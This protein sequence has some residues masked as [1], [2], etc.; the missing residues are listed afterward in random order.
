MDIV[1]KSKKY[2][3]HILMIDDEDYD[4]IKEHVWHIAFSKEKKTF[5]VL[6]NI[7]NGEK[8]TPKSIHRL[9]TNC[10]KGLVVD[11]KNHN[12]FDNRKEN[13]RICTNAENCRNVIRNKDGRSSIY[14]G[15]FYY[16]RQKLY[17]AAITLDRKKI[18]LGQF[19]SE[20]AAAEAYN[21]AAVEYHKEFACLN[22]IH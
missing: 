1:I 17:R 14:K 8:Y 13:L 2:G 19:E 3:N 21:K 16:S 7:K 20:R 22:I 5:S 12:A 15:V 11:H 6:T 4:K 10:P 18:F 9:L